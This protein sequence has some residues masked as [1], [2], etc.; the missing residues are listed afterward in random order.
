M[1]AEHPFCPEEGPPVTDLEDATARLYL[2][3]G[4][5]SRLLRRTGSPGLGP[6]AVSA[7]ATL[8]RCGPMRL[9]DLANKEG[10]A[11]PT[12]SRIVATLVEAG[13]VRREPDPQDGRAW[14]ASPT[15]EGVAMVSGVRSARV[16]ELRARL[17]SLS[18]EHRDA[19]VGALGALEALVEE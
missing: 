12:L 6:G 9:G 17:E 10:V 19:L 8:A 16:Q 18:P 11:P 14:L 13:Y 7:L 4:R 3:I 5:L 15:D 2:T 1:D